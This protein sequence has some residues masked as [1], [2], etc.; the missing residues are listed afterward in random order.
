MMLHMI[1]EKH[2]NELAV[3]V[4]EQFIHNRIRDSSEPQRISTAPRLGTHH[5]LLI[6]VIQSMEQHIENPLGMAD[7]AAIGGISRR[8]LD[9][10]FQIHL[11]ETPRRYYLK[12]RLRRARELLQQT[13]MS[14]LD[15]AVAC[16]FVAPAHFSRAYS[17][18]FG[19]SPR[20][21]RKVKSYFALH[22]GVQSDETGRLRM[23]RRRN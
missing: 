7:L 22:A 16:G 14:V 8:Q 17:E 6:K 3:A 9:R 21:D 15:I 19:R 1:G 2:G 23:S 11:R 5:P 13:S 10:L 4:A 20:A 18:Q 12:M